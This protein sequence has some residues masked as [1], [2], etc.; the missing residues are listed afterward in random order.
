MKRAL[1]C[2]LVAVALGVPR[3]AGAEMNWGVVGAVKHKATQLKGKVDSNTV[4]TSSG[5]VTILSARAKVLS[6][7][8]LGSLSVQVGTTYYFTAPAAE[9]GQLMPGDLIIGTTSYGFLRKVT[10]VS[11]VVAQNVDQYVVQTTTATLEDAYQTLDV[12]ISQPL[13]PASLSPAMAPQ[14]LRG[15][16]ILQAPQA[17]RPLADNFT[18]SLNNVLLYDADGDTNTTT[19]QIV[20]NGL[21]TFQPSMDLRLAIQSGQLTRARLVETNEV[22]ASLDLKDLNSSLGSPFDSAVVVATYSFLPITVGQL[23]LVPE[24]FIVLEA[25]GRPGVVATAGISEH[26]TFTA[27]V[28]YSNGAWT[29]FRDSV[30]ALSFSTAAAS[31]GGDIQANVGPNLVLKAYAVPGA[32][33]SASGYLRLAADVPVASHVQWEL[34]GGLQ[35]NAGVATDVFSANVATNAILFSYEKLLAS[36]R[37]DLIVQSLTPPSYAVPG[38]TVTVTN[39]VKNQGDDIAVA[40]LVGI[41][42]LQHQNDSPSAGTKIAERT[43]PSLVPGASSS[44]NTPCVVPSSAPGAYFIVAVADYAGVVKEKDKTNNSKAQAISI[45]GQF[46]QAAAVALGQ[47]YGCSA[48]QNHNLKCWG[49]NTAEGVLGL[50][51]TVS[52]GNLPAQMGNIL[53]AVSLGT[54]RTV[55]AVS[56]GND[57]TCALLDNNTVKC[58]GHNGSGEL[59][60]GDTT[61][62]GAASSQM[63]G[64]LP[65]VNLGAGRTAAAVAVGGA[66]GSVDHVCAWLDDH[67]VK[68]WGDN[69]YGQ[70]GLGDTN[71][72]GDTLINTPDTLSPVSFGVGRTA[73]SIAAGGTSSCA[74]LDN[75]DLKCWGDNASGQLGLGDTTKRGD[76]PGNTPDTLT[77]VNPGAGRTVA[78]V[79]LGKAHTCALLDDSSVKCWGDNTSGQLGLG[80]T[81]KRG[82]NPGNTPDTLTPVD[83][84]TGRTAAKIALGE[85]HTCALLDN[86]QVK[87]WG[88]NTYGQLGLGDT[89]KRGDNPGQM[90]DNLSTVSLGSGRTAT[91]IT[92]GR[93][94]TCALLDNGRVKCWGRNA[95]GELGLGDTADRGDGA[96]EMGDSLPA[97]D[98]GTSP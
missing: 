20:A 80:D 92:A 14:L 5:S 38:E 70:L 21:I 97:L 32:S 59:G 91:A 96:G 47:M 1:L 86:G 4:A 31:V 64:N 11:H 90:G 89:T 94:T 34:Y 58:W 75:N 54:G 65:A 61:P 95:L 68:C 29:V 28:D 74:I 84:G 46:L 57:V 51:D 79:A 9:V 19:D 18:L 24:L 45:G 63:G 36:K 69:T 2:L 93:Y 33:V 7:S 3:R 78:A 50:G 71:P 35:G 41:Y 15:V 76:N 73:T 85:A 49:S 8:A 53:P 23:V 37:P 25:K 27:G 26:F 62:R 66:N 88:D 22:S 67:N 83:L 30:T 82:D 43:A 60:L 81:T 44:D 72:R 56:A 6:A 98:L 77:P 12:H 40:S 87:C 48:L 52:R 17:I 42:L 55:T 16:S 39:V 13:T 10:S